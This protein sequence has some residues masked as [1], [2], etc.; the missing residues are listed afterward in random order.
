MRGGDRKALH[1]TGVA[2]HQAMAH[3]GPDDSDVWQDPDT[4]IVLAHRRLSIIDLSP[5]GHQPMVSHSGRYMTVYNGE[6]YNYR[7]IQRDLEAAGHIFRGRSDTE[8]MLTA[9]D[10]WGVAQSLQ[11]INGMFA[12]AV[13]DREKKKLFLIRDRMGKKPLYVG[14]AGGSLLFASELKAFHAHPDFERRID[15]QALTLYMRY[16]YVP[17]PHCIF[18]NVWTVLPGHMLALDIGD[19]KANADLSS[20]MEPYWFAPRVLRDARSHP[21]RKAEAAVIADFEDL[22]RTCV[23]ERMVSDVPLGAFL[24][25]GID[26]STIVALMQQISDRP[27]KTFSIGFREDG[28]DEAGHAKKVATHLGAEHHEMYVSGQD[29]LNVIPKLPD[30]YDEP[31][32]DQSQIPT[33]LVSKFARESVTVAL[34]G[35]GGDEMLGG[36]LRHY[37]IPAAWSK[38]SWIPASIR[39]AGASAVRSL[40]ENV[41]N[42]LRPGY[43]RFGARIHRFALLAGLNDPNQIYAQV[44]GQWHEPEKIVVGGRQSPIPLTDPAWQPQGLNF[45]ETMMFGDT[46]SYLP[47]DILVK[48]DRASMAVSLEARSPLLDQR[49]FEYCWTL[50]HAM[51]VRGHRGKWLLREVLAR[52][53]P[54]ALFERPKQGFGVPLAEWL[55]G[56]LKDWAGDFLQEDRL[57]RQGYLNPA[58]VGSAWDDH[59]K[60]HG[61][62]EARL[63]TVLMFQAWLDRWM[64]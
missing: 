8:V 38:I 15:T 19:L 2:M 17:A 47:G 31:F 64:R 6:I 3:R 58:E 41:Y 28:F 62:H 30:I 54:R 21:S 32:A 10:H 1:Q 39:R 49:V 46:I 9:F 14:W 61:M 4:P 34:S 43:P 51:K 18:Q 53:V 20:M 5:E 12:I 55:R 44:V 40:P 24:S 48:V 42:I 26:S 7:D 37:A 29:A 50:P 22:L 63:W 35:D 13:W 25:G 36:Y 57:K 59:L 45:S 27:V 52:H 56:P 11:K 23:R 16:A 33:Y 60:G